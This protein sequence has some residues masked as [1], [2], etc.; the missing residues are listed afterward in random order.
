MWHIV[1]AE[2]HYNY[3]IVMIPLVFINIF[4]ALAFITSGKIRLGTDI[5]GVPSVAL[6][7]TAAAAFIIMVDRAKTKRNR[8]MAVLPVSV[9]SIGIS[10]YVSLYI[11]WTCILAIFCCTLKI[12]RPEA[13]VGDITLTMFTFN[14][15]Y[16]YFSATYTMSRDLA[17][18]FRRPVGKAG[19]NIVLSTEAYIPLF[20][21]LLLLYF[22]LLPTPYL[23]IK[24]PFYVD[25][26]QFMFSLTGAIVLNIF[27]LC[28]V[29][30][31][32]YIYS[33]RKSF[34]E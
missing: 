19:I 34:L 28:L 30:A 32:V 26:V 1:K 9:R 17:Y 23:G 8:F 21:F 33:R 27:G 2:L 14:G 5:V 4:L 29:I 22:V 18:Y 25:I 7:L 16:L 13:M 3:K 15:I 6:V 12:F 31:G 11:F 24:P 20:N 10:H